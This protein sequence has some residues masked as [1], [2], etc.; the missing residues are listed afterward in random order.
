MAAVVLVSALL[1]LATAGPARA[2]APADTPTP[3]ATGSTTTRYYV[4]GATDQGA[5]E[6]LYQIAAR[7]LGDG[8]RFREIFELNR[9]RLQPDGERLTDPL[10][11]R[12]G[13]LL[14]LPA[15]ADGPGVT[16]G[17]LP[18]VTAPAASA[19]ET[20]VAGPPPTDP[21]P[22]GV[23]GF[24]FRLAAFGVMVVLL[25]I[26]LWML[27]RGRS[28]PSQAVTASVGEPPAPRI[29]PERSPAS[30][31]Q[32]ARASGPP[33]PAVVVPADTG[34][35]DIAPAS[36][37]QRIAVPVPPPVP[38]PVGLT[39]EAEPGPASDQAT[40]VGPAVSASPFT[41]A[42]PVADAGPDSTSAPDLTDR[43]DTGG[44]PDGPTVTSRSP[45]S[46]SDGPIVA[47]SSRDGI[48]QRF[49]S[50]RPDPA[51]H[52]RPESVTSGY[53]KLRTELDDAS[54]ALRVQLVGAAGPSEPPAYA[55]LA[56]DEQ[57]IGARVPVLL[58]HRD[59]WAL[60]VDLARTPDVLTVTGDPV[61]C[62][63]RAASLA[64]QLLAAGVDVMV[65]GDALGAAPPP[66]VR[67][68][69]EFPLDVP[70]PDSGPTVVFSGGLRGARLRA[71][72]RMAADSGG[73]VVPVLT[74]EVL[75][76]R[77]SIVVDVTT[78]TGA[79]TPTQADGGTADS[80][81]GNDTADDDP[82]TTIQ[83]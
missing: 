20:P 47:S 54:T 70:E 44:A 34:P 26:V 68:W 11:L 78:P 63:R 80:I 22:D 67:W 81:S 50:G 19:S 69:D 75:R 46:T 9:D 36:D 55:W 79:V 27:R 32:V 13:W 57:L 4:V 35:L 7:T 1:A 10:V 72:R 82:G 37:P 52:P 71:A 31:A 61:A 51:V 62:R 43:P 25:A 3:A 16:V 24:L 76:A 45:A 74:G 5:P 53:T 8:N 2:A 6:F 58:G 66:G 40:D 49:T 17:P 38:A 39:A 77:W 60:W 28:G 42:S 14:E 64:G 23:G 59:G 41:G 18:E 12:E 65:V 29:R 48:D 21:D 56:D 83:P 73:R 15:D 33:M 30:G